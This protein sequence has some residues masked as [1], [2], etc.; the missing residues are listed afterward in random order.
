M[1]ATPFEF[2]HR[3]WV[4]FSI[5]ILAFLAYQIDSK[6]AAVA[7][8]DWIASRLGKTAN[9][10]W[11][12]LTFGAASLLCFIAALLRTWGTSYLHADVMRDSRV[13]TERLLADGPYRYVRNPLYLG[14]I[15]LAIGVG[16]MASR[17]GFFILVLGMIV[18]VLRLI[19]REEA[20]LGRDQG[21]AYQRYR[22]AVPRLVPSLVPRLPS[23]GHAPEWGQALRVES[24]YWLMA[25]AVAVFAVTL[26]LKLFWV[27]FGLGVAASLF[28]KSSRAR[29]AATPQ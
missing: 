17:T 3:W 9:D 14:N 4:I 15:L 1:R 16:L 7:L 22:A 12:R 25:V 8:A 27:F 28:S 2:R 10:D 13:H 24:M 21:D 18:F 6:N 23:A 19:G 20:D 29:P 11:Y 26:N 5:F